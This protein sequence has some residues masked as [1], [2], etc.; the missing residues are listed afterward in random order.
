MPR[1]LSPGRYLARL[2]TVVLLLAAGCGQGPDVLRVSGTVRRQG[3]PVANLFL[4]FVPAEGRPSWGVTDEA[5]HYTLFH[6]RKHEGALRG[7]HRVFAQFRPRN[8]Q[9]EIALQQGKQA[10]PPEIQA[11]L[12]KYG[13]LDATPLRCEVTADGQVIDLDLD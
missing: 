13:S 6:D 2:L 4:N 8:P 5:G 12:E 1:S 10:I 7:T 11:I 3:S 9:Q